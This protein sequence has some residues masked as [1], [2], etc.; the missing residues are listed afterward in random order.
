MSLEY[1]IFDQNLIFSFENPGVEVRGGGGFPAAVYNNK[2][3]R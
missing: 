2:H 3:M 1:F